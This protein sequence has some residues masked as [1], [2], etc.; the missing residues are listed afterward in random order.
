MGQ[1][2]LRDA[3]LTI[4]DGGSASIEIKIGEGNISWTETRNLEYTHDRGA[5]SEVRLGDDEPC[6]LSFDFIWTWLSSISGS[7]PY[8]AIKGIDGTTSGSDCEPFAVDIKIEMHG[9]DGDSVIETITFPE[10]RYDTISADLRQ[11]QLSCSGK[12]PAIAPTIT[13]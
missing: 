10:F 8:E 7:S 3:V 1:R 6:E 9:C 5:V 13:P 4:T 11:G 12:I 2:S